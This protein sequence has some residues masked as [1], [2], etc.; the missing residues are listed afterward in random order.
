MSRRPPIFDHP[1][2]V[3]MGD[4]TPPEE[5]AQTARWIEGLGFSHLTIPEDCW[6][7][8]ALIGAT[9][10]LAGTETIPVGTSIISGLTRHPAIVSMELAGI[11]RAFPGR[12][13]AGVGLG[14]PE[15]LDQ[16]GLLPD[17]PVRAL[18]EAVTTIQRLVAGET[19]TRDDGRFKLDQIAITHPATAPVPITLGVMG[20]M[21]LRLSGQIADTTLF[22]AAAGVDYFHYAIPI[23]E[24]AAR[25]AGRDPADLSF[26][27]I[28]LASVD[29]DGAKARAI[30]RP[31]LAGFLAEFGANVLSDAYGVTDELTAMLERGGEP[32]LLEEMPDRWVDDLMLVGTPEEVVAKVNA[33]LDA[34]VS[35]I[36][37][38]LPHASEK[39]TL[40]LV[41]SDV[42]PNLS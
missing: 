19:V 37:M 22:G 32:V 4:M 34:G 18:R 17:K 41:A 39:D 13:R 36:A 20:P 35:S 15:W 26:S 11:S 7:L 9:L 28:A 31:I 16:M 12:F 25:D 40:A 29:R 21:M 6:Y 27:T 42:I 14:L 8:P 3:A 24:Q 38:F 30:A 10:A 5:I 1:L 23:V 33:W 2:G